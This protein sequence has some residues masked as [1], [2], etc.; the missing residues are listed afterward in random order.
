M[1]SGENPLDKYANFSVLEQATLIKDKK[2][3][4]TL[5][6]IRQR[7]NIKNQ[8]ID[9]EEFIRMEIWKTLHKKNKL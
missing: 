8:L 6:L 3:Q 9:E 7:E 5:E 2:F 1:Q 4:S